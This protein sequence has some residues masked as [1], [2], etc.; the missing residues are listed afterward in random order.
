[1]EYPLI[2]IHGLQEYVAYG[3]FMI[4]DLNKN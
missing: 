3:N 1:M 2:I 4:S